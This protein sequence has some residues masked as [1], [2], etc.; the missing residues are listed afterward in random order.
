MGSHISPNISGNIII[1][2]L[3][4]S[5]YP[6]LVLK[7]K[8]MVMYSYL[9]T[10]GVVMI[11]TL[12]SPISEAQSQRKDVPLLGKSIEAVTAIPALPLD[13]SENTVLDELDDNLD[14]IND[15]SNK[16]PMMTGWKPNKDSGT[17]FRDGSGTFTEG[18]GGKWTYTLCILWWKD[19][20]KTQPE[21]CKNVLVS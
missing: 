12:A 21:R 8:T 6:N 11:K 19:D 16:L 5:F 7:M 9:F 2:T 18:G 3:N 13:L 20:S 1:K 17:I 14:S 4:T 10:I 15:V